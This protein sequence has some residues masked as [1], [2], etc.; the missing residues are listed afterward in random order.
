MHFAAYGKVVQIG[1]HNQDEAALRQLFSEHRAFVF[2]AP[3]EL[4]PCLQ[5]FE[6]LVLRRTYNEELRA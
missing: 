2:A 3:Q 4:R 6:M 1:I 5:L